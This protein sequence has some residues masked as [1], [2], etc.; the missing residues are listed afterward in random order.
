MSSV[1]MKVLVTDPMGKTPCGVTGVP[2]S[3]SA[4]PQARSKTI[5]RAD[6]NALAQAGEAVLLAQRFD[7]GCEVEDSEFLQGH[8]LT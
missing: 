3:R 2:A 6:G 4:S 7:L 1:A 8:S 5:S